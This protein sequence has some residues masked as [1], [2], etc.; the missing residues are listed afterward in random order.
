ML[1]YTV[2]RLFLR[3]G[4]ELSRHA[5]GTDDDHL[6]R[7]HI[8]FIRCADQIES[9]RFRCEDGTDVAARQIEAAHRERPK[10]VRIAR[11]DDAIFGQEHERERAFY[12]QQR[13]PQSTRKR[14]LTRFR[15]E[16]QNHFRV[17]GGLED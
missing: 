13:L 12:L 9:T 2:R 11:Y 3:G 14:T 15:H 17:A 6:T 8:A 10:A 7:K 1:E 4:V 16:V 5:F